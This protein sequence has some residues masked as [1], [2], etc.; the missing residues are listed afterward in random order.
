MGPMHAEAEVDG[1]GA[2][3]P[4]HNLRLI[5]VH[6]K[7]KCVVRMGMAVITAQYESGRE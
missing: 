3:Q 2:E 7:D 1:G 4:E 6:A 5:S